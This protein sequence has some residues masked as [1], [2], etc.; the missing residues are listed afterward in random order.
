MFSFIALFIIVQPLLI[1]TVNASIDQPIPAQARSEK[2][3][4]KP[5]SKK[6]LY[7][8]AENRNRRRVQEN[9]V[10]FDI[11]GRP[12]PIPKDQSD[13]KIVDTMASQGYMFDGANNAWIIPEGKF[14]YNPPTLGTNSASKW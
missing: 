2:E 11:L 8:I 13:W 3:A 5:L 1:N 12:Y 6:Q 7:A 9:L 10:R 14:K 4:E